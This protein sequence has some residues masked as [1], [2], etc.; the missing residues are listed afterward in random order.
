MKK[1][2]VYNLIIL[3][4][5]LLTCKKESPVETGTSIPS[6][7]DQNF[8][9]ITFDFALLNLD[10]CVDRAELGI[11]ETLNL[12]VV[13][14]FLETPNVY[15]NKRFYTFVVRP[16]TY[17]IYSSVTCT[18]DD[19]KCLNLGYNSSNHFLKTNIQAMSVERGKE[20]VSKAPDFNH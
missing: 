2:I 13:K 11:A 5:F 14:K 19:D 6:L 9:K 1:I 18:C 10:P 16:G 7:Y 8:G 4:T 15:S 3:C 20:V 12:L 17:Y